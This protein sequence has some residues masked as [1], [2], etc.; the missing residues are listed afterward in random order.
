MQEIK[1]GSFVR[2]KHIGSKHVVKSINHGE[3]ED[4]IS[5][6]NSISFDNE[7]MSYY[8]PWEPKIDE[9]VWYL[10]V[11]EEAG[12]MR[13]VG[14]NG[15]SY[16]CKT[17]TGEAIFNCLNIEP[18]TG[19]LPVLIQKKLQEIENDTNTKNN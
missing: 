2:H 9:I 7:F 19:L 11:H 14:K 17:L 4:K 5:V 3:F 18:F 8:I 1:V 13:Y 10:S 6:T 12:L 16:Q 15:K